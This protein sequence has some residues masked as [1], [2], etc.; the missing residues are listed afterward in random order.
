M[1]T[2]GS[3]G[4]P[5]A[6]NLGRDGRDK[7]ILLPL[8]V[9]IVPQNAVGCQER[10]ISEKRQ[11]LAEI[12]DVLAKCNVARA[13]YLAGGDHTDFL[14]MQALADDRRALLQEIGGE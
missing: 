9:V 3:K 4:K 11:L 1:N 14:A 6:G 13:R 7:G 10:M 5:Q 8:S 12:D 2:I